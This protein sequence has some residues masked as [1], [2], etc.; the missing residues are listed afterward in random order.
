MKKQSSMIILMIILAISIVPARIAFSEGEYDETKDPAITGKFATDKMSEKAIKFA[1]GSMQGEMF[2]MRM[3]EMYP[4]V[5]VSW[6]IANGPQTPSDEVY[7]I[8]AQVLRE[9]KETAYKYFEVKV[10]PVDN[11]SPML[12]EKYGIKDK[13][14]DGEDVNTDPI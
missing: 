12:I 5:M 7:L 14:E 6:E 2:E 10:T 3:Q 4:G 8:Q 1:R 13:I 11:F 9:G